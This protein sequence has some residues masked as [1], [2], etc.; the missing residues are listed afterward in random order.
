MTRHLLTRV[1]VS[2]KALQE[3][4]VFFPQNL[5]LLFYPWE[6]NYFVRTTCTINNHGLEKCTWKLINNENPNYKW[7]WQ[8]D[9]TLPTDQNW[10]IMTDFCHLSLTA[11]NITWKLTNQLTQTGLRTFTWQQLFTWLW[12]WLLLRLLKCHF[13]HT[14][15]NW[16]Y[17][18]S[19]WE[20]GPSGT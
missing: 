4:L 19:P 2:E 16:W 6:K 5:H 20:N 1:Y 7:T 9:L 10:P 8:K 3:Q 14:S 13:Y 12:W 17:C 15:L 18:N 11:D